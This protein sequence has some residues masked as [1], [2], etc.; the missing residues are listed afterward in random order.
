M[1]AQSDG[2]GI[3]RVGE[4]VERAPVSSVTGEY[5]D[6]LGVR[7]AVGR[8]L[9]ITDAA[10]D[11]PPVAVLG[12][13][14]WR[15]SLNSNPAVL[16]TPMTINGNSYT[17]V[18][19][20][21]ES[22]DGLDLGGPVDIWTALVPPPTSS[23]ARGNRGLS[24]IARLRPKT[25]IQVA[26]TQVTGIATALARAFPETN[27]GTL[28]AP[29][30]PRPM[31]AVIH[32][33]MPPDFRP[34]VQA[35]S[36][37][38]I[39]AVGLVLV[40]ACANVAA[41]LV[42]RAIA[43]R[44]E[45]AVRLALGAGRHRLVRQLLTE[46]LLLGVGGGACG[47]LLSL[48]TSETLP[49]FFPAEQAEML[50]TSVDVSTIA[51]IATLSMASS[52]LFGL[53]PAFHAS[54]A[55]S[56]AALRGGSGRSSDGRSGMRLRR[57]LV[58]A[59]I[60]AAVVLLVCSSLLVRSLMNGL[61]ADLGFATRE[62]VTATVQLPQ[63]LE[64]AKGLAYYDTVLER[65]RAMPGVRAAGF[66]QTLP[67]FRGSRRGFTVDGYQVKPGEDMELVTNTV[68]DA[69]FETMQIAIRA[70]RTFDSRDRAGASPVVIV[71]D[72][73]AARF[74]S[75]DAL[76]RR[77]TDSRGRLV[78]IVGVVQSH[79]YLTVQGSRVPTVYF[80][81]TQDDQ[82]RMTLV[83]RVDAS[84]LGMI[85][86]IRREMT[87]VNRDVP[88]Y[89]TVPLSAR[90]DESV[91]AD[92]LTASLVAVCGGMAL[93]LATIGVYGVVAYGVVR[94]SREIGI[95]IALGARPRT[96]YA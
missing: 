19:V 93:L 59:Q 32:T 96:W 56:V 15:R 25:T 28:H 35:V 69:Y 70:G 52:L 23:E 78:E 1:A 37:V 20:I 90:L 68:S 76:G 67:L 94:R 54:S 29:T 89:R 71:N 45:M 31:V 84:P 47:L 65:V 51:F 48:W 79:N 44:Q 4:R 2:T 16:D 17:I 58:A 38:L 49:S 72:V 21:A 83:A 36:A 75:G 92:R 61:R 11:A 64:G 74:F 10:P 42:S 95:R 82:S 80:P 57:V 14:F 91:A 62:A 27:L 40:I 53:V 41:L 88:V 7:P 60:A 9:T 26:Q 87:A 85:D 50:D 3:V 43:R 34:M 39:A 46:S 6:L 30:E 24:I 8:L 33:R 63:E 86:P 18:G 81:L 13:R 66:A 22:F 12:Q 55:T 77:L 73:L 5:F